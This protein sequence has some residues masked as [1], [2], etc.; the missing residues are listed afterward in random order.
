[1]NPAGDGLQAGARCADQPDLASP[2][3]VITA[4]SELSVDGT[5]TIDAPEVDLSGAVTELSEELLDAAER[6]AAQCSAR[7][8]EALA[9]FIGRGRSGLPIQPA[10]PVIALYDSPG[11]AQPGGERYTVLPGQLVID[12]QEPA[13]G[14]A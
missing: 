11:A 9:T 1:M 14:P 5:V 10:D 12:C 3:T 7:G 6:L 13:K 4:S 2:D 8:G